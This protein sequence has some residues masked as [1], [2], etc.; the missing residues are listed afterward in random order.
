VNLRKDH[1]TFWMN[2]VGCRRSL[3]ENESSNRIKKKELWRDRLSPGRGVALYRVQLVLCVAPG[4]SHPEVGRV[5]VVTNVNFLGSLVACSLPLAP[6]PPSFA[7]G[8]SAFS[9]RRGAARDRSLYTL[10][11]MYLLSFPRRVSRRQ[12][13]YKPFCISMKNH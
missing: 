3:R 9:L 12:E 6:D 10:V 5:E 4:H 11:Y 8:S 2:V 7:W 1:Y 13:L